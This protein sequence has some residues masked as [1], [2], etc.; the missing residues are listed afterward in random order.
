ML[1]GCGGGY[2]GEAIAGR[3]AVRGW[4]VRA[5]GGRSYGGSLPGVAADVSWAGGV[6]YHSRWWQR[7]GRAFA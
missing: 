6:G 2:Q 1:G 3:A 5:A 7:G 4:L